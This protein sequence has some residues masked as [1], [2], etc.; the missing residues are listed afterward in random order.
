M[1]AKLT[2][3]FLGSMILVT[4]AVSSNI[5]FSLLFEATAGLSTLASAVTITFILCALIE[6]FRPV[7]GAHFNPVLTVVFLLDKKINKTLAASYILTQFAGGLTGVTVSH[8]M[9]YS[10][11]GAIFTLS[12]NTSNIFVF[13]SEIF[14]T[15]ILIFAILMLTKNNIKRISVFVAILVGGQIMATSSGMIANPQVTVARMFTA[16]ASGIRPADGL[17]FIAMQTIG[18]L[19][20]YIIYK[21]IFAKIK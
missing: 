2:A 15:F 16:T 21:T 17:I 19:F 18:A 5:L 1:T 9:F 4:A 20:A 13:I 6:M 12:I 11:V 3:E 14:A 7:S 8:I 10:E